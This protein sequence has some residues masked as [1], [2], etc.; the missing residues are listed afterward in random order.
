M[1]KIN[2]V[3]ISLSILF[4]LVGI[5]LFI[6]STLTN[7]TEFNSLYTINT[8][9][10][11]LRY[12]EFLIISVILSFISAVCFLI[13]W[14]LSKFT[15]LSSK[16]T[17]LLAIII[18]IIFCSVLITFGINAYSNYSEKGVYTDITKDYEKPNDDYLKF[19]P[20]FDEVTNLTETVPYYSLNEYSLN[21]SV[22]RTSQ[23]YN[24]IADENTENITITI[25]YFES[26]K[27][28]L[29]SKY[30]SEKL[31]YETS[32]ENG[33]GLNADN[34]VKQNYKNYECLV[35][36]LDSEKRFI[37]KDSN[38]Y[39]SVIVQDE[40]NMLDIDE[41]KF[42]SFSEKQFE[43]MSDTDIFAAMPSF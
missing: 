2:I 1:K 14:A 4:F 27:S 38:F 28:Y 18:A 32:D 6:A 12:Y 42:V 29:M 8:G 33:N 25:D 7:L 16:I 15:A 24:D 9:F 17:V 37:I 22:L 31:L 20:Y 21:D 43:L 39:F 35:I 23:I 10:T 36:F 19:F 5:I 41:E 13:I 34:T 3:Y 40:S 30:E 11:Q 26:D